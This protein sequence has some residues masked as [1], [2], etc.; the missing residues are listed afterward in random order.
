L[1]PDFMQ[2]QDLLHRGTISNIG[3][4]NALYHELQQSH[5]LVIIESYRCFANAILTERFVIPEGTE[6][7]IF[8]ARLLH[9]VRIISNGAT[10]F[11]LATDLENL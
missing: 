2:H 5:N 1:P 3:D 7:E 9:L 6:F 8:A 4:M 10:A 11:F